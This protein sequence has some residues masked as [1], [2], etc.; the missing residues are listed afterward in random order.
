MR[1]VRLVVLAT[2]ALATTAGA[3]QPPFLSSARGAVIGDSITEQRLY[4]KYVECWLLACSGIPDVEVMQ[5]GW[6][7]E[8]A[9]GFAWR[10]INDLAVFHPTVATLCYGM[11][12]GGYQPWKPEIGETYDANMRKVL[13]RLKE[14]GVKT[15][16]VGSPGAVDTNFFRPGQSLGNQPAHVA[17]NDT[18]AH[19]RDIDK[20]LAAEKTFALPTSM[21]R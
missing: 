13:D 6:S 1:L 8:K 18:L 17:Y 3:E 15:V 9:D 21:P 4:S 7:G 12:D 16:V 5:F 10:A 2:L 19:L 20:Q 11:N 14:S